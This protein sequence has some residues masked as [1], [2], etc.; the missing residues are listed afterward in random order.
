MVSFTGSASASANSSAEFQRSA[1]S[2]ARAFRQALRQAEG[3]WAERQAGLGR[4]I[5][6][7]DGLRRTNEAALRQWR[8][9][10]RTQLSQ[11]GKGSSRPGRGYGKKAAAGPRL[12]DGVR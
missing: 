3:D 5:A 9:R 1:G 12:L 10:T 6:E 11:V 2:S 7:I 8:D 4:L